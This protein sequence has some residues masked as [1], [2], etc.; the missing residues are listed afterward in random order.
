MARRELRCRWVDLN[1]IEYTRR[2]ERRAGRLFRQRD[3][4][5]RLRG[6]VVRGTEGRDCRWRISG[7]E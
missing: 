1:A 7:P 3:D 2:R 5:E 6:P 4:R